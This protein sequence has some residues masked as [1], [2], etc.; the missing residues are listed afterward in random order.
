[1]LPVPADVQK[2]KKICKK[3]KLYLIEDTAWGLGAKIKNKFLGTIGDIG[4]LSVLI[5]QNH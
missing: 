3:K 2:I 1:M 5:L 4:T